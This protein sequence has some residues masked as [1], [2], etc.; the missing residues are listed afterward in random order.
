MKKKKMVNL[1]VNFQNLVKHSETPKKKQFQIWSEAA[2]IHSSA[3]AEVTIRIVHSEE[4]AALNKQFRHKEGSTNVLS[5]NYDS[6][7]ED[8]RLFLGDVVIC[9][10]LVKQEA[11]TE[12]KNLQA[13]WAHLTIHGLLHLQGYDHQQLS[14]AKKMEQLE[15]DIMLKLGFADPYLSLE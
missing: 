7:Q 5:F 8:H 11:E 3:F 2:L 9:A 12:G 13:H 1:K 4:S 15:T 10:E 14:D 6:L